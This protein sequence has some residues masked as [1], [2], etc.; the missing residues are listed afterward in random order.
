[1]RFEYEAL[2]CFRFVAPGGWVDGKGGLPFVRSSLGFKGSNE[3][4]QFIFYL[5]M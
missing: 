2:V 1:M 3:V 5:V 4:Q